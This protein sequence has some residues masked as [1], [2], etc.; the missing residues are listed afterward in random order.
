MERERLPAAAEQAKAAWRERLT[1]LR[2][3]LEK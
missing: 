1:R 2:T 3:L